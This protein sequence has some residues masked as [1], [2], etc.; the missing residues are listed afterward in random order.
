VMYKFQ[1][2]LKGL[3]LR[4]R[5]AFVESDRVAENLIEN[6]LQAQYVFDNLL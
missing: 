4:N 6:R 3:S 2:I 1:G 5:L